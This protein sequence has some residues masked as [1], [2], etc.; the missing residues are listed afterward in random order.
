MVA[1]KKNERTDPCIECISKERGSHGDAWRNV[2]GSYFSDHDIAAPFLDD[3][4][5]ALNTVRPDVIADIGG[6]TGFIL[7]EL[8]NREG[9]RGTRL[10]NVDASQEQLEVCRGS[11]LERRCSSV[12]EIERGDLASENESL[13]IISR[14]VLHYFGREGQPSFL[15]KLR[16]LLLPGEMFIHQPACFAT[17]ELRSCMNELYPL[18]G[19]DKYYSTPQ[20]LE[21]MHHRAGFDVLRSLPGPPLDLRSE[22]LAVRYGLDSER[23]EE[24]V[25]VIRRYGLDR[26]GVFDVRPGGF[27]TEFTYRILT[28][29]AV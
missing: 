11:G 2:H 16:S 23:V 15:Q 18:M 17:P 9:V 20:D 1:D 6:G 27:R 14:S 25:D 22:D 19:V 21:E 7:R 12:M 29:R 24:L 4:V 28:L 13:T 3:I 10:L 5:A 26:D 8:S